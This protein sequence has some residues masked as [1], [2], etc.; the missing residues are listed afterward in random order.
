MVNGPRSLW[1]PATPETLKIYIHLLSSSAQK[2]L[3]NEFNIIKNLLKA[4]GMPYSC[5]GNNIQPIL[6]ISTISIQASKQQKIWT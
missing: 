1:T 4:E 6:H 2:K 3:I 5:A